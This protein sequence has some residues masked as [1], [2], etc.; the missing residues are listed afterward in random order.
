MDSVGNWL[1]RRLMGALADLVPRSLKDRLIRHYSIPDVDWSL[2]NTRSNGFSPDTII[3]VGA[4]EGE[5]TRM[6]H[7]IYPDAEILAVEPL[8]EKEEQLQA[9]AESVPEVQYEAALLGAETKQNVPFHVNET[10]SSVLPESEET[11]ADRESRML[12]T[13]DHLTEGGPFSQPDLLKLDVQGY[14]LE[15]LR[16]GEQL[17]KTHPPEL[18]LM[19]VSLIEINEG[20]PLIADVVEFM[21]RAD[22]RL[23]DICSFMRRPYDD[24]LWQIDALFVHQDSALVA[25]Q[26]WG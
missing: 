14:E 18:I 3:D 8:R 9:L 7:R 13:L 4:Y 22:Y 25:S 6:A 15:V 12:T 5:W 17:L 10:V 11:D 20:A 1:K 21:S 19:E 16:G 26:R 23:Y 2:R 24:A